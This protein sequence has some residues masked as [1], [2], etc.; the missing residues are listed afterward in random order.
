MRTS[1]KDTKILYVASVC[2]QG[3]A[4][5]ARLR[6]Q[7]IGRLLNRLGRVSLVIAAAED[8][9]PPSLARTGEEYENVHIARAP[10]L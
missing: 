2:P 10:E 3:P 8:I 9:D 6:V 5:G 1:I 7:N 4:F